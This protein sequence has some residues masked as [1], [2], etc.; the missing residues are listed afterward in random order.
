[1]MKSLF[2]QNGGTYRREGDYFVPNLTLPEE[3]EYEIGIWG[4]RRLDYLKKHKRILYV[5]L[6]T[7]GELHEHLH[8]IDTSAYERREMIVK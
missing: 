5:H 3:P 7:S 4:R 1:M 8:E 2:E 6:L